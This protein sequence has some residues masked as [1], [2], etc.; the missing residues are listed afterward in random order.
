MVFRTRDAVELVRTPLAEMGTVTNDLIA[1]RLVTRLCAEGRMFVDVGAHIGAVLSEVARHGQASRIAAFEAMP[2]KA[3]HLKRRFP[4]VEVHACAVSDAEGEATFYID[5]A[6]SGYSSLAPREAPAR[7]IRVPVCTL[8]ALLADADVDVMKI[9]VEGAELAVLRGAARLVDRCRPVIMFE[10]A[11]GSVLGH[12]KE[13][14]FEWFAARGYGILAPNRVA[15]TAPP[16]SLE[17]FLDSHEYPRR[18]TDFF[19]IPRERIEEI[20]AKARRIA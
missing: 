1:R 3:A 18:T 6:S 19:A 14:M 20:R 7:E 5:M 9:D 17:A 15:H 4:G 13:Q 11:P 2:D 10:S 16:M 12:T 8:D